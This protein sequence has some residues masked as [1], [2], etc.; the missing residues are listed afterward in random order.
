M[1]TGGGRAQWPTGSSHSAAYMAFV[2]IAVGISGISL[3]V[4]RGD[5]GDE[6]LRPLLLSL[7]GMR[8]V[9]GFVAGAALAT[10]GVVVQGLFRNPLAS[11]S[12]LGTTAGAA[13]GGRLALLT[14]ELLGVVG[15]AWVA[16]DM[17]VPIGCLLGALGALLILLLVARLRDDL[18]VLLLTGFLLSTL[19]MSVGGLV[20]SLAQ[21]RWE[22]SRALVLFSLGDV[23]HSGPRQIAF[24]AP[25]VGAG[26]IAAWRWSPG[27]DVM[28]SGEEEAQALG[29]D[30][31][32]L[33]FWAVVWVAVLTGAA[34]SL[35]GGVG[36]VGLVVPHVVRRFV[37]ASHRRLIPGAALLGGA[38]V[39]A[40]D[41]I[42]RAIPTQSEMPLGV[43][44]GL[45][46]GPLFLFLLMRARSEARAG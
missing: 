19:F 3:L 33:R 31:G 45:I 13:L 30:V 35:C 25:L 43:V 2:L 22:L 37:G 18:V 15:L 12:V 21:N 11:P 42:A 20:V 10:G 4:G 44:T 9:T 23:S 39:V 14:L 24:A 8:V 34:V 7:R 38:F 28:L 41:V 1:N 32:A 6:A 16:R 17:V 46:G 5:L 26:V 27:L 40:C 36:F 29:V